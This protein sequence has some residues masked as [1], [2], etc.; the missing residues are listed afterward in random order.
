VEV[1]EEAPFRERFKGRNELAALDWPPMAERYN[2]IRVRIYDPDDRPRFLAGQAIVTG[3]MNLVQ[4]PAL[5]V[6]QD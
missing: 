1:D 2:P 4:R 5:T 6:K 3:N